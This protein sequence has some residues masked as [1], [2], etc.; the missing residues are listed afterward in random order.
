MSRQQL[1]DYQRLMDRFVGDTTEF[2]YDAVPERNAIIASSEMNDWI[3]AMQGSGT[4]ALDRALA[5]WKRGRGAPWLVAALWKLPPDHADAPALLQAAAALDST[6]PAFPTVAFLR[7]RLLARRGEVAQARALLA[8]LPAAPQPG[9]EPET[10]NL[11]AA[12]RLM[13]ATTLD[14]ALRNAPRAIVAEYADGDDER[15]V[16]EDR[17]RCSTATRR[18]CSLSGSRSHLSSRRR[19]RR[20]CRRGFASASPRRRW[21]AR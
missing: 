17:S 20:R 15:A 11:L 18:F 4:G 8:A 1:T 13:L 5:Q 10:L 12:E 6:S 2:D 16:D 14:E 21:C 19:P 9:F 7:V 3:L